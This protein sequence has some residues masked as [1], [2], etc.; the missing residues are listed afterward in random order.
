MRIEKEYDLTGYNTFGIRASTAYFAAVESEADI[1]AL[2]A[3]P[4]FKSNEKLFLGGGSNILFTKNWQGIAVR[5]GLKGMEVVEESAADVL[6]R[7]MGGEVWHD[8]VQFAVSRGYWG[9]ENLAL[10][11]GSVGAAPMQN[12]GAYGVELKDAIETVEAVAVATGEKKIFNKD[13]CA[14]GY[15]DSIFKNKEKG[16]VFY[17]CHHCASFKKSE[18][19]YFI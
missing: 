4:E 10:I 17:H 13:Q 9:I 5:D 18:A 15:R 16:E 2:F 1:S 6:L 14:F 7:A 12:I 11:P 3:A 8:F 19:Q